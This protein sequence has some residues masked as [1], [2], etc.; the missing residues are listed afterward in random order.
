MS[1]I[2]LTCKKNTGMTM[3]S[4]TFIGHF[5]A[6]ANGEYVKVYLYLLYLAGG[7]DGTG[8]FS[9]NGACDFLS[10]TER[11]VI[12]ALEYWE[13]TGLIFLT[14]DPA[15]NIHSVCLSDTG[16]VVEE[17]GNVLAAYT[18]PA[19]PV[20]GTFT[21]KDLIIKTDTTED[22][23]LKWLF[24]IAEKLLGR[25]LT[26]TDTNLIRDLYQKKEF[27]KDLIVYLY[28]HCAETGHT[29]PKYIEKV[30]M[31]WASDH[32]NTIDQAKEVSVRFNCN[33][34]TVMKAFGLSRMPG[35]AER[36]YIDKW[37]NN[38]GMSEELIREACGRA[39]LT[40]AKPDFKYTDA[41]LAKWSKNGIRSKEQVADADRIHAAASNSSRN[42]AKNQAKNQFNSFEQRNYTDEEI[43]A[44][45]RRM[46]NR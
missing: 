16:D 20:V 10:C 24:S 42:S 2:H 12:R 8:S 46:Q 23:D 36:A 29:D 43:L 25:I 5:M 14:K 28:E 15:G 18:V 4:N 9:I 1:D 22:A 6:D 11:D 27:T 7:N 21:E 35:E 13:R 37:V 30:A 39:L 44:I 34:N 40:V 32:V 38:Y 3:V 41:I 31:N 33:Y 26:A 17:G 45:E 19:S